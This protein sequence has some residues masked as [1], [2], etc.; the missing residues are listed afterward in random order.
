[1]LD[2]TDTENFQLR[3][4]AQNHATYFVGKYI[5]TLAFFPRHSEYLKWWSIKINLCNVRLTFPLNIFMNIVEGLTEYQI[6]LSE[7]EVS[8]RESLDI[9]WK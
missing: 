6:I 1:M 7:S 9:S 5:F 2:I 3:N 8:E 4:S